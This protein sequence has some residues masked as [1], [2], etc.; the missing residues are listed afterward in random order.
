LLSTLCIGWGFCLPREDSL[1][2][3]RTPPPEITG[4]T[5]AAFVGGWPLLS[6]ICSRVPRAKTKSEDE[7]LP[8]PSN[9]LEWVPLNAPSRGENVFCSVEKILEWT[10]GLYSYDGSSVMK[11]TGKLLA[12]PVAPTDRRAALTFLLLARIEICD[13]NG[14]FQL[15]SRTLRY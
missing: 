6:V 9:F 10:K 13:C 5:N 14:R 15:P 7:V 8:V 2:L 12:L 11:S 4:F 1:R 3:E